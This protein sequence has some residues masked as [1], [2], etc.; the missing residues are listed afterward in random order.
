MNHFWHRR[1]GTLNH[2]IQLRYSAPVM[3]SAVALAPSG[4]ETGRCL[5]VADYVRGPAAIRG[6]I[7]AGGG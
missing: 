5:S 3:P 4:S 6:A 7:A 1:R 2:G